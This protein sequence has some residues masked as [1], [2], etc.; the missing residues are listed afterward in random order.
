MDKYMTDKAYEIMKLAAQVSKTTKA[1]VFV[2]YS[3]HVDL[4]TVRIHPEGYEGDSFRY[5]FYGEQF[6][7]VS[8]AKFD[9]IIGKLRK[10]LD[11]E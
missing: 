5:D 1:D 6:D 3:G 9:D 2:E 10:M 11:A 4:L 8:E 7:S